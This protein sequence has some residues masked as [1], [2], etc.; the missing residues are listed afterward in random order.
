MSAGAV[1]GKAADVRLLLLDV[2]GVLT[3][4]L[5]WYGP[6]GETVKPFHAKDGF[7]IRLLQREGVQVGILSARRSAPLER[8]LADLGVQHAVLGRDDKLAGLE[9]LLQRTGVAPEHAASMGD[10]VLDLPVM[11]RVGL[12]I[13]V[14]DGHPLVR[15]EAAWVTEAP[16]GRGAVREVADGILQ[17]RGRLE[18]ACEALLAEEAAAGGHGGAPA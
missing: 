15:A 5:L 4:G 8:R 12:A 9:T 10:D 1:P 14:A 6:D 11:R 16:G 7:G 18:D 17:A 3:D 2:D 13:T